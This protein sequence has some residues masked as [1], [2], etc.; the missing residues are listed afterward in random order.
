MK[1]SVKFDETVWEYWVKIDFW[2]THEAVLILD[3]IIPNKRNKFVHRDWPGSNPLLL[4]EGGQVIHG[5]VERKFGSAK[6]KPIVCLEW[7]QEIG[8][9]LDEK[10]IV[11]AQKCKL[12]AGPNVKSLSGESDDEKQSGKHWAEMRFKILCRALQILSSPSPDH[13]VFHKKDRRINITQLRNAIVDL[14]HELVFEN[15]KNV[16][17]DTIYETLQWAIKGNEKKSKTRE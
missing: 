7:A 2:I 8:I 11:T 4:S 6:I 12:L 3:G 1:M 13:A 14:G 16:G 5:L 10:L 9:S 15:G 17:S